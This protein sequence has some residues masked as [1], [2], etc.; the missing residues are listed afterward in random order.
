MITDDPVYVET[1]GALRQARQE[2]GSDGAH[3]AGFKTAR[4][5]RA[6]GAYGIMAGY[7]APV[8]GYN[9]IQW[10]GEQGGDVSDSILSLGAMAGAAV[11]D[12]TVS[13]STRRKRAKRYTTAVKGLQLSTYAELHPDNGVM[14][15]HDEDITV[16]ELTVVQRQL[17]RNAQSSYSTRID[18]RYGITNLLRSDPDPTEFWIGGGRKTVEKLSLVSTEKKQL[19]ADLRKAKHRVAFTGI[20]EEALCAELEASTRDKQQEFREVFIDFAGQVDTR[21]KTARLTKALETWGGELATTTNLTP[22]EELHPQN[23]VIRAFKRI[24]YDTALQLPANTEED[25]ERIKAMMQYSAGIADLI[26]AD[27]QATNFY[28]GFRNKFGDS[29]AEHTTFP[30][31]DEFHTQYILG[32]R[33]INS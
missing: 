3:S 32:I 14:E 30:E 4:R 22:G 9:A 16:A 26:T 25:L 27:D 8:A 13:S 18:T 31:W 21:K 24:V 20:A 10:L 15:I 28:D 17:L 12:V 2:A 23:D 33:E 29:I 7:V 11:V 1:V 5:R 19:Q 6:V